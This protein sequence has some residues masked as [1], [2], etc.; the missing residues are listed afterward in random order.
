MTFTPAER[1]RIK[2][3]IAHRLSGER[4]VRRVVVFGSFLTSEVPRDLDV[5]IFQDSDS[6]YLPLALKYRRI[7][8]GLADP[9]PLDVLPLRA[10]IPDAPFLADVNRG[11]V[12]Y[13]G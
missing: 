7:L 9:L 10:G 6:P 12:V 13:H 2:R 3:E 11:E 8:R 5:A 4:E 1:D